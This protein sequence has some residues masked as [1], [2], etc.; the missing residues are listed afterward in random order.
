MVSDSLHYIKKVK[1]WFDS[2]F[3][4]TVEYR[5]GRKKS[6]ENPG[7]RETQRENERS[8]CVRW[9]TLFGAVQINKELFRVI[10]LHLHLVVFHHPTH[11]T[12]QKQESSKTPSKSS[13]GSHFPLT[14]S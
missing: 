13:G 6:Q 1:D 11:H 4:Q 14:V 3:A 9:N 7:L 10:G 8:T 12:K 2:I 5:K